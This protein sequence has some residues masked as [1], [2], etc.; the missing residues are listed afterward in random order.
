MHR[1]ASDP[2]RASL[3]HESRVAGTPRAAGETRSSRCGPNPFHLVVQGL[4]IYNVPDLVVTANHVFVVC[5]NVSVAATAVFGLCCNTKAS[6]WHRHAAVLPL[7][8]RRTSFMTYLPSF[9]IASICNPP[10]FREEPLISSS[11]VMFFRNTLF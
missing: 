8:F 5:C 2:S 7:S 9:S 6:V 1:S 11:S 10:I 4:G 3:T